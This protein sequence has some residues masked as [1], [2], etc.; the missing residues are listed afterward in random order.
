MLT[1]FGDLDAEGKPVSNAHRLDL[2]LA[3]VQ[4]ADAWWRCLR[5]GSDGDH[6]RVSA[7][8]TKY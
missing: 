3:G 4:D 8:Q 7:T 1:V 2:A 6:L 5:R